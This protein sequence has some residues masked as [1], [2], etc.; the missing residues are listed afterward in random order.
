[1]AHGYTKAD[2]RMIAD[3]HVEQHRAPATVQMHVFRLTGVRIGDGGQGTNRAVPSCGYC[4]A[5]WGGPCGVNCPGPAETSA[6]P[7]AGGPA[8]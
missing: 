1:M 4:G 3:T 5:T 7:E 6:G 8:V 2:V